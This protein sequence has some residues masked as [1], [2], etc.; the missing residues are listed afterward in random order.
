M[1]H[2]SDCRCFKLWVRTLGL[3]ALEQLSTTS[4]RKR[5]HKTDQNPFTK[6]FF[7]TTAIIPLTLLLQSKNPKPAITLDK[8]KKESDP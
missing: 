4:F 1:S 5:P 8:K 3:T 6:I 2:E 7:K